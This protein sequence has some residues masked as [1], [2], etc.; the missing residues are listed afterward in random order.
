MSKIGNQIPQGIGSQIKALSPDD[1][2]YSRG[3]VI[4]GM[5]STGSLASTPPH[6][7]LKPNESQPTQDS[8]NRPQSQPPSTSALSVEVG[9]LTTKPEIADSWK[10]QIKGLIANGVVKEREVHWSG[11]Q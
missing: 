11:I 7:S 4:G 5:R 1:P 6:T 3:F 9:K 8:L 2:V 10:Q